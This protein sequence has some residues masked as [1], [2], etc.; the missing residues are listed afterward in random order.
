MLILHE[1]AKIRGGDAVIVK[2]GV[3]LRLFFGSVRYSEDI[4]LDGAPEAS[5]AIRSCIKGIF[6]DRTFT[7]NL[8][9][10]GIRGLDPGEGP[11]GASRGVPGRR[12]ALALRHGG[13]VG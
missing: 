9:R 5:Q 4:D 12:R 10:I 7:R 1:L 2:G 8:Q 13:R 6:R 3:N 11:N